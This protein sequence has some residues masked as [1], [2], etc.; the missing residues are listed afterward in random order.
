MTDAVAAA[1][2]GATGAAPVANAKQLDRDAFLKLLIAQLRNQNPMKP[3][4]DK[5]FI[6][7]L[8]QFSS[9]EQLQ[10]MN[11]NLESAIQSQDSL[12]QSLALIGRMV[13]AVN[14]DYRPG[15]DP[16][17]AETV[18]GRVVS[19]DFRS[20]AA[21]L[22]VGDKSIPLGNVLSVSEAA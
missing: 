4:E 17:S 16:P 13:E 6:A 10:Q 9:L 2:T 18:T 22:K 12:Q 11:R 19:V 7:Q 1:A 20:G 15:V 5:E 21:I 3:M 14:P 8:A